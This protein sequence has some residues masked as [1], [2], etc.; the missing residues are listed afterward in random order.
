[1]CETCSS[2]Y[3]V[4]FEQV[5]PGWEYFIITL[6]KKLKMLHYNSLKKKKMSKNRLNRLIPTYENC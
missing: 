3:I 6:F 4:D 2:V 5:N 1:M